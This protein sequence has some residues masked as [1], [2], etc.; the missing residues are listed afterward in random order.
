MFSKTTFSFI[1]KSFLKLCFGENI[2]II[3]IFCGKGTIVCDLNDKD[4][5]IKSSKYIVK[6]KILK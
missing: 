1:Y 5:T 4:H 6:A 2:K 3:K